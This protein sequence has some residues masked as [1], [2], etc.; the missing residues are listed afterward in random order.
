MSPTTRI[1]LGLTTGILVGFFQGSAAQPLKVVGDIYIGLMQMTVLPFV[2]FTLIGSIGQLN[3]N[4][5][6]V[7]G[8]AGLSTYL[9]LWIIAAVTTLAFAQAFPDLETSRFFSSSL[10]EPPPP[11]DWMKLFIPSNPFRALTENAVPA[12]VIF[13]ILF[14]IGL[15]GQENSSSFTDQLK[16]CA[17][18]LHKVN[19]LVV[20]LTPLG[21]FAISAHAVSTTPL[22]EF[23]RLEAYYLV[24]GSSI[25]V[26][27]FLVLPLMV[28]GLTGIRFREILGLAVNSLVTAF[29]TGS[30]LSSLPVLIESIKDFYQE[31]SGEGSKNADFAEFILPL[32]Y[33]FPNSGNV[34]ALLFISF[35]AWFIGERLEFTEDL[36]LIS[37]GTFLMFGKVFL[38]IP[39]LL[40]TFQIPQDMFQL[41]LAAGVL[42]GRFGDTL[43][44][45]H[46]VAFTLIATT[47]MSGQFRPD[48]K[49]LTRNTAIA[50]LSIAI[51]IAL[52]RAPLEKLSAADDTK[53]LILNRTH[54]IDLPDLNMKVMDPAPN[55]DPLLPG[56]NRLER[57]QRRGILRVGYQPN[58]LPYAFQ[59]SSN[60]LVGLDIDLIRKF[61]SELGVNLEF[62][63]FKLDNLFEQ[64]NA[65]QFDVALSGLSV[66]LERAEQIMLSEPYLH[67][68]FGLT[69]PDHLRS[70]YDSEKHLRE[71]AQLNIAIVKGRLPAREVQQHFPW[72]KIHTLSSPDEFFDDPHDPELLLGTYAE[73]GAAWTLLHPEYTIVNPLTHPDRAPIAIA[74]AGFDLA[75]ESMLNAWIGLQKI[76]GT[77]DQ[78]SD[79]WFLGKNPATP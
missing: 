48:W 39:F 64:I 1:F 47:F 60:D 35:A 13:C 72:A 26:L 50:A 36:Y 15:I 4:E 77:L 7:L 61:A 76:N 66:T 8:K 23:E 44:T 22:H 14:G 11:V 38:A 30:V 40:N 45:M 53:H 17:K 51:T 2:V 6:R 25:F 28:S 41:F 79:Y 63:P 32:S 59:N 33:P 74:I 70:R 34:A 46:Y 69:V 31:R 65:D 68:T 43:G 78:L 20:Q 37:L 73:S 75:L 24:I 16:L 29:V 9:I 49:V 5:L 57:I 55:S 62:V 10:I 71:Q 21:I 56:E 67:V 12:V 19:G 42:A 27:T 18:S 52:I 58:S 54:A 3:P